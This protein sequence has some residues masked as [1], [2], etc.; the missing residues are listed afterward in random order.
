[1]RE[2]SM[3]GAVSLVQTLEESVRPEELVGGTSGCRQGD[4]GSRA[5]GTLLGFGGGLGHS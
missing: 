2:E 1:M 4:R 5:S 3:G